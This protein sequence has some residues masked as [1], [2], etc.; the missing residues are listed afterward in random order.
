LADTDYRPIIGASLV[1]SALAKFSVTEC[2]SDL[3]IGQPMYENPYMN[4]AQP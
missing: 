2:M 1:K 3:V 4:L